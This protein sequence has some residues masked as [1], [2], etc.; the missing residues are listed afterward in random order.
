M[1]KH[2]LYS[3]RRCPYAIRARWALFKCNI[4]FQIREIDLKKKSQDI[5][6]KSK[7]Q[8]VPLLILD[9]D[10]VIDQSLSII[11]WALSFK[12]NI[13][14]KRFYSEELRKCI[15]ELI[16]END[17]LL[18]YHLD[19]F[20]YASRYKDEDENF[21]LRES[22]KIIIKWNKLLSKS[23]GNS[24]WLIGGKET[25]A[26]WCLFPFVR[27]FKIACTQKKVSNYFEEPINSWLGHFEKHPIFDK[28][29]H[30]FPVWNDYQ[31]E[32]N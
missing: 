26:D 24:Y 11:I 7:D 31:I 28:V 2:I 20:K 5:L 30:K 4:D 17:N 6:N 23:E 18:K 9:N 13:N 12:N 25:I 32:K 3:F 10:E 22:R 1:Q 14:L 29:M 21:H 8:T 27:Q 15:S 19:R 16:K